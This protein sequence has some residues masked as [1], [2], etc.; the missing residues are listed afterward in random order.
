MKEAA[1]ILVVKDG[2]ILSISRRNDKTKFGLLGGKVDPG[3]TPEQAAIREAKEESG[4][5]ITKLVKIY[6]RTE[7]PEKHGG[8]EFFAHCFYATEWS[9]EPSKSEEGE[10]RWLT[11]EQVTATMSAF[12]EYNKNTL[13]RFKELFPEVYLK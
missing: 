11:S 2:L 6:E 9:G 3:E 8:L 1:V 7:P 12:P 10:L 13:K 4:I 5:D